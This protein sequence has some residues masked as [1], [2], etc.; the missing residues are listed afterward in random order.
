MI[1]KHHFAGEWLRHCG[2]VCTV[3]GAVLFFL[4]SAHQLHAGAWTQ[5][6]G[7]GQIILTT[8]L[9]R[10]STTFDS[11]GNLQ[12]F[13]DGGDFRQF[14]ARAY[15][16]SGLTKRDTL[17]VNAPGEFLDFRNTHGNLNGASA[18]DVEVAWKHLFS[19]IKSQWAVSGQV[20]VM[21]P[22]YKDTE[23]PAPGNHQ[24]DVEG[25][26]LIGRGGSFAKQ[27]VF[28]DV[29][30]AYRYRNGA[31]AD[32]FRSDD[33]VGIEFGHRLMAM[34]QVFA[35]KGMQNGQPLTVNANPNA[36]SDFDLYKVQPSLVLSLFHGT[37]L[38][39]GWNDAFAGRNTGN[40]QTYI[41]GV[42]KTF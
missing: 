29:E 11:N 17:V 14:I 20:L 7:H 42:W 13:G 22:G 5:Q 1:F 36:Q 35:I 31:P 30:A 8:S 41:L 40:G 33:A 19:P 26:L 18:G 9:Y 37:R 38:Q 4:L 16:E 15:I 21:F 28:M 25:R 27:H 32:Q 23:S 6:P 12:H 2:E 3:G 24:E 34:G 10:T 39:V